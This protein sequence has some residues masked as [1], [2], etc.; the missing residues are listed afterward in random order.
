MVLTVKK[1]NTEAVFLCR[2]DDF[3]Y[4]VEC[5]QGRKC[6]LLG[7]LEDGTLGC[8]GHHGRKMDSLTQTEFCKSFNCLRPYEDPKILRKII[9]ELPPGE[10]RMSNVIK[11]YHRA[12]ALFGATI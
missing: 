5:C 12:P 10:F 7:K 9:A 1:I 11:T 4:C 3:H 6:C 2:P 8:L